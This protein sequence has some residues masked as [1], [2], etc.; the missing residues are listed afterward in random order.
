MVMFPLTDEIVL[1][2]LVEVEEITMAF[3]QLFPLVASS[4]PVPT[5][6][7]VPLVLEIKLV[8]VDELIRVA[9]PLE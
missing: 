9:D 4:I 2:A 5:M 8:E 1:F 7:I 3:R 6:V